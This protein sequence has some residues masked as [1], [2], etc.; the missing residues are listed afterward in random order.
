MKTGLIL[1]GGAYRGIF[2]TGVISVLNANNIEFDYVAGVSAGAGN[3]VDYISKR[4]D[5][6]RSFISLMKKNKSFGIKQFIKSGYFL[7]IDDM[8]KDLMTIDDNGVA[9][10]ML[11]TKM[12]V[13][14]VC[15]NCITGCA[16][17]LY[18]RKSIRKLIEIGKAS[19][20]VPIITKPVMIN[21][22]P[23][24]DGS[25]TDAIPVKRALNEKNCDRVVVVLTKSDGS[26]AT[27]YSKFPLLAR[28]N[29]HE[30]YPRME[31]VLMH[32]MEEYNK[33]LEYIEEQEKKGTVF[34]IRPSIKGV[35]KFDNDT[36]KINNFYLHGVDKMTERL[37]ALKKFLEIE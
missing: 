8:A 14:I 1:E 23:Y 28:I 9:E 22:I 3:L 36:T 29:F 6:S 26:K 35:K 4:D 7:N 34:I 15:S 20:S 31:H 16:D 2:T 18:E 21:N 10:A 25:V 33:E 32:R 17:Y 13:E 19:C 27:D 5:V 37:D 30:D 24:V 12:D 11:N